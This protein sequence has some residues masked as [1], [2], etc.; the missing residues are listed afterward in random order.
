M[1]CLDPFWLG[2]A[3]RYGTTA[4]HA[5]IKECQTC[6]VG[7]HIALHPLS[8]G[9]AV[10]L[11]GVEGRCMA[12]GLG[13]FFFLLRGFRERRAKPARPSAYSHCPRGR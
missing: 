5:T 10:G 2:Q 1:F 6:M 3:R 11:G 9:R 8:S 12:G 4:E 13:L 7:Y